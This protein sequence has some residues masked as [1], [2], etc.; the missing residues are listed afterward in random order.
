MRTGMIGFL[1]G[2]VVSGVFAA[3]VVP[4]TDE[5]EP[6]EK[7]KDIKSLMVLTGS[8]ELGIQVVEQ[9][10]ASF[11]KSMPDIPNTFWDDFMKEIDADGLMEIC[12]PVYDKH[13]SH[14]DIK[15]MIRFY[16]S[17]TGKRVVK[18]LP[19]ITQECMK[20]GEKWGKDVGTKVGKQLEEKGYK[21]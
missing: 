9:M 3:A 10:V 16:E 6:N 21:K 4:A 12:V 8:G 14:E 1:C 19:V 13:L 7:Q 11:K 5:V 17:P 2:L 18:V 20:E 15:E